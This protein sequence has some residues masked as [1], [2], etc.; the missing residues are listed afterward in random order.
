MISLAHH[1]YVRRG[2]NLIDAEKK[3]AEA[4]D[5]LDF[6]DLLSQ[7]RCLGTTDHETLVQQLHSL[8]D[9]TITR[10]QCAF[11]LEMSSW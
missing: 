4:T 1:V 5:Q 10:E 8:L 6:V 2:C 3:M 7:F 9:G 11:I